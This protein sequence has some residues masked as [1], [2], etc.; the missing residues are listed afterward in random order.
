MCILI[1]CCPANL[2]QTGVE[3]APESYQTIGNNFNIACYF[4]NDNLNIGQPNKSPTHARRNKTPHFRTHYN[5][6]PI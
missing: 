3:N 6:Y 1:S 2:N 4:V 5:V